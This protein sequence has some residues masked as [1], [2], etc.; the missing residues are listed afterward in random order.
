MNRL[1]EETGTDP[2]RVRGV[3]LLR[4][5]N[6][7]ENDPEAKR[8]VW[9]ALVATL[10]STPRTKLGSPGFA[11]RRPIALA[12][13]LLLSAATAGAMIGRRGL[14]PSPA[15]PAKGVDPR[16]GSTQV[17]ARRIAHRPAD[18]GTA[19]TVATQVLA[20]SAVPTEV[21]PAVRLPVG[22]AKERSLARRAPFVALPERTAQ[23]GNQV[24]LDA[25]AAL[26]RD[27]DF[28]RAGGLLERFLAEYPRGALREEAIALTIEAASGRNDRGTR[29]SWA[30]IYLQ[31]YPS[32][33]F[34]DFAEGSLAAP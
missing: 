19:P 21:R 24:L 30:R 7:R 11:R 26:R 18:L 27:R 8:R 14:E 16:T 13:I 12:G 20:D 5:A 1:R 25:M 15:A 22:R 10:R 28:D 32:G 33:R 17:A 29:D 9:V 4:S 2:I 31:S 3:K 34:R 23:G 6:P